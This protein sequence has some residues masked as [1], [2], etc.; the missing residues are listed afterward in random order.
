MEVE[1]TVELISNKPLYSFMVTSV[2]FM[3][4]YYTQFILLKFANLLTIGLFYGNCSA[5]P[6]TGQSHK[7]SILIT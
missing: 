3:Y 5:I 1:K 7:D 2:T 6:A 4:F